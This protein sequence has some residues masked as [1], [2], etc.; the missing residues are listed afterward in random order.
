MT[1]VSGFYDCFEDPDRT[2]NNTYTIDTR[3]A[4]VN[5]T[6]T[7]KGPSRR[8]DL[9]A[10]T[11]SKNCSSSAGLTI[12]VQDNVETPQGDRRSDEMESNVCPLEPSATLADKCVAV[13]SSAASSIAAEVSN[14]VCERTWTPNRTE[15]PDGID[16][17]SPKEEENMGAGNI[18]EWTTCVAFLMSMASPEHLMP[19]MES[20]LLLRLIHSTDLNTLLGQPRRTTSI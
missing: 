18:F 12:N 11:E 4:T 16:C 2:Y 10:A 20:L 6:F 14:L 17:G 8:V 1:L 7:T 5:I 13:G 15:K 9:F 3:W 19:Q